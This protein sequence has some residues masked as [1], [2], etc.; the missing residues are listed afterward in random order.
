MYDPQTAVADPTLAAGKDHEICEIVITAPDAD[1]LADF[2]RRLVE[3][4]LVAGAHIVESI[5]SIYRW[6]DEVQ[7]TREARV[8]LRTRRSLF[9]VVL[10]RVK[11]E[12]PYLMPSVNALPIAASNPEYRAW[13]LE[14]TTMP[15]AATKG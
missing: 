2:T 9:S 1:W 11:A 7:D 15:G 10:A 14:Q 13:V 4:R 12:H 5:R 8:A 6:K 3:D